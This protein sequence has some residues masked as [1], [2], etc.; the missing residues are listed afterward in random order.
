MLRSRRPTRRPAADIAALVASVAGMAVAAPLIK[1]TAS[2]GSLAVAFWRN[3]F[4]VFAVVPFLLWQ[5]RAR[6]PHLPW[7]DLVATV[8]A[9]MLFALYLGLWIPS[10]QLTGV[11]SSTGLSFALAPVWVLVIRRLQGEHLPRLAWAG[12]AVAVGGVVALAG[13]DLTLSGR[14]VLGDLLALASGLAV[15]GYLVIGSRTRRR[16]D[17]T[18]YTTLCY[19]TAAAALAVPCL[20]TRTPITGYP[21]ASW[22][23]LVAL[24]ASVQLIGHSLNSRAVRTLGIG[25]TSTAILLET[26]G[27][28]LI[29]GLW[30][31]TW[32]GPTAQAALVAVLAGLVAVVRVSPPPPTPDP[33]LAGLSA[34]LRRRTWSAPA[35]R[36]VR[37]TLAAAAV[38]A[39]LLAVATLRPRRTW[40]RRRPR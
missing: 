9:G 38:T 2:V 6:P 19:A 28:A 31:R 18:T 21:T 23:K 36:T 25:I 4:A 10:L 27:A 13:I 26:P 40:T 33:G 15:A 30:H 17:T 7:K 14:R 20:V 29:E 24:T 3:V 32:P 12:T 1:D 16:V 5:H 8:T 11:A 34:L 22:V 37:A 35:G 39:T